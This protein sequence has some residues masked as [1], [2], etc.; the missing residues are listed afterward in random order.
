MPTSIT[1]ASNTL[2]GE[3]RLV[4]HVEST[5]LPEIV[6]VGSEALPD[7]SALQFKPVGRCIYC[8]SQDDLTKEHI[9]PF[10]LNG[11]AVLPQSSCKPCATVTGK[12]E[13][14][15]L[16]GPLRAVRIYRRL[17]SRRGHLS[18]PAQYPLTIV[19][20]GVQE[21]VQVPLDQ[22]PVLLHFPTFAVPRAL[23]GTSGAGIAMSG[24]TTVS[25]GKNPQEVMRNLGAER[26]VIDTHDDHPTAFARML[27]KIAYAFAVGLGHDA[28]LE[29]PAA[30]VPSIL[31]HR[32]DIGD[33]VGTHTGPIRKYSGA[34]HRIGIREDLHKGLLI[35]DVHL[36]A[37]SET[38]SYGVVLGR[39]A[40]K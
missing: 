20:E 7:A 28:L 3:T 39:L 29:T 25:F 23:T 13:L 34:L 2:G 24:I 31:G 8:G 38:P 27:A 22:Y 21:R 1:I 9:V 26:I 19:R 11:N 18:A 35:A 16:R 14:Q 12:F 33:W 32:D 17:Q 36:F 5:P 4:Q 15:V 6:D 37:D 30:I 40:R 10:A